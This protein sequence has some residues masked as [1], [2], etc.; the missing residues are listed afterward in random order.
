MKTIEKRV[1][2]ISSKIIAEQKKISEAAYLAG[3]KT[4]GFYSNSPSSGELNSISRY[5]SKLFRLE[6]SLFLFI[7]TLFET[8]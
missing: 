2:A 3:S 6:I 4:C 5:F 1:V 8:F 7:H